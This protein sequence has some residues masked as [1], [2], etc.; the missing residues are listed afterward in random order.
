MI[1][2]C[3]IIGGGASG[4]M[5]ASMLKIENGLILEGSPRI[6]T[7]LL[8]S[9]GGRCNITN[10]R[11]IKEFPSCYGE[12]SRSVRSLL[13]KHS[14]LELMKFLEAEG[15]ELVVEKTGKVYPA[16]GKASEVVDMLKNKARSNGWE[17]LCSAKVCG[18]SCVSSA[19][20]ASDNSDASDIRDERLQNK[21]EIYSCE[22]ESGNRH[23][24]ARKIVIA[25]GGITYPRTGSDGS[26]F[27]VMSRD[28]GIEPSSLTPVL[29]AI[30]TKEYPYSEISGVSLDE[31]EISIGEGKKASRERESLIFTHKGFSGPAILNLSRYA[32]PSST[33]HINYLPDCINVLKTLTIESEKSNADYSSIIS[34]SFGL[35]KSFSKAVVER[36]RTL[37]AKGKKNTGNK[38]MPENINAKNN[39]SSERDGV[40]LKKISEILTDDIFSVAKRIGDGMVTR[41]GV[42]LKQVD[43]K[44]MELKAHSNIF[45]IGEALDVD[46]IS[47]GY[48]LQFAYSSAACA[49]DAISSFALRRN[50][51]FPSCPPKTS[52]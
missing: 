28:L 49:S 35:P 27:K 26:L 7:K 6:G 39:K 14:N 34:K 10:A 36:A 48:N 51:R 40:S 33:M 5:L 43:L 9:G 18:I 3:I 47:G 46:G 52:R 19:S 29:T 45:V 17:I 16:S 50:T 32:E 21:P 20:D 25:S 1:Y 12:A 23:F 11:S 41:G 44:R 13:Y 22:I 38:I 24:E 37:G 15:I 2:D 31:V 30:E 4:L 42:P 8:M